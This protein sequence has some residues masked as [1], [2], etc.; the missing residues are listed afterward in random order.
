MTS[1]I[2]KYQLTT[3]IG[4]AQ[5]AVQRLAQA[6]RLIADKAVRMKTNVG[7]LGVVS[8]D[9]ITEQ[10]P[11]RTA[12]PEQGILEGNHLIA[13]P[14]PQVVVFILL[15]QDRQALLV[16]IFSTVIIVAGR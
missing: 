4:Y 10:D 13:V 16:P 5:A 12:N 11:C 9:A 14:G 8:K 7:D 1:N 15:A 6:A 2:N 3:I